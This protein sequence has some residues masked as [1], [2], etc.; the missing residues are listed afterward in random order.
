MLA[1][2]LAA[3]AADVDV[4][5]LTS[6]P[7]HHFFGYIGHVRTVPWNGD[8]TLVVGLRTPFQDRLP[9]PDE[10][11][12]LVLLDAAGD[13]AVRKVGET[14]AWNFQQG[15]MLCWNPRAPRTQFFYNDRDPA[16]G[17][18]VAALFDVQAGRTVREFRFDGV[19]VGNGGVAPHGRTFAA[20]NYGR[21]ARLRPVT[22]YP[23]ARDATDG[24]RH[25]E[26]D[27]VFAVDVDSGARTLL[28]S[29]AALRDA[30]R[31]A[32]PQVDRAAL[33]INHTLWS[34]DGARLFFFV[35]GGWEGAPDEPRINASFVVRADG[36]GLTRMKVHLGGH[37]E[38][39]EGAVMI[40]R[41][42]P[43]QVL[44]D[45]ERQDYVGTLGTPALF[46][47]PEGDIALSPD[48]AWFV[49]GHRTKEGNRYAFLRRADGRSV[50][51]PPLP[52]DRWT[53]GPLRIDPAPCWNRKGDRVLVT[54]LAPD[55]ART[56]QMFLIRLPQE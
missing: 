10:A 7:R 5:Q 31:P 42:G 36:S 45:V 56:R 23:G 46:P 9:R 20:I 26:D 28:A 33:F 24:I 16:D 37:P 38:W 29:F 6:G 1:L 54:A 15:T 17:R 8:D 13:W 4:R 52:I 27:G 48:G 30:V 34:R 49:N 43:D 12:D 32:D 25:P 22:G 40:G 53:S 3:Q 18:V 39:D 41:R 51:S 14:R 2:L 47:D 55:E 44:Y 21:L 11:A 50:V 35:R 19:A